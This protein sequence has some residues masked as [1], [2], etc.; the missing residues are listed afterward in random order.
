MQAQRGIF[1]SLASTETACRQ[2]EACGIASTQLSVSCE[3][4]CQACIIEQV[5]VDRDQEASLP[6]GQ[7][8]GAVIGIA[9]GLAAV[10]GPVA[11]SDAW[12]LSLFDWMLRLFIIASWSLSGSIL[13]G[14]L[15]ASGSA[16]FQALKHPKG[17]PLVHAHYI[18]TVEAPAEQEAAVKA[19]IQR[20][21]GRLVEAPSPSR[22]S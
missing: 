3:D 8:L 13:G 16:A 7:G 15:M 11:A 2:L 4:D 14:M 21:G 10:F 20:R 17:D 6:L 9:L 18:L 5:W 22:R 19:I 12:A 1:A